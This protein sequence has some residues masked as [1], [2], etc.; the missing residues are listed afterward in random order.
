[1]K[2]NNESKRAA[3]SMKRSGVKRHK[4]VCNSHHYGGGAPRGSSLSS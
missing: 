1:M 2:R 3:T 4:H